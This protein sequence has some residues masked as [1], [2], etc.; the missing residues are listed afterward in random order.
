MTI[1]PKKKTSKDKNEAENVERPLSPGGPAEVRGGARRPSSPGGPPRWSSPPPVDHDRGPA[2]H[3]PPGRYEETA[4][5]SGNKRRLRHRSPPH[6]VARKQ[7]HDNTRTAALCAGASAGIAHARL[8][9]IRQATTSTAAPDPRTNATSHGGVPVGQALAPE[10]ER[11]ACSGYNSEDECTPRPCDQNVE[12]MERWFETQLKEKR[13]Y[14]IKQMGEDGACL[15]RAVADQVYGDQEM[16]G[17]VRQHCVDYMAKN[18]DFYKQFV[19]EDFTTYLNRKRADNCHGNHIEMQALSELYNRPIEVYKCTSLDPINT[20]HSSYE[21]DNEPIRLSY[22]RNVHYNSVV[23]PHKAT[24]G[25]GLGLPGLQPGLADKNLIREAVRMSEDCHIEQTM[26]QDK[27]RET[28]WE[29]TQETIEEQV[30]RESYLQWLQEQEK[31]AKS[32]TSHRSASATCSTSTDTLQTCLDG[33]ASPD[34]PRT[35]R[36]PRSHGGGNGGGGSGQNS[37]KQMESDYMSGVSCPSPLSPII[38]STSSGRSA[39]SGCGIN[40]SSLS[41]EG[42]VGGVDY[43]FPE[44]ASI[45]NDLPPQMF[46]LSDYDDDDVIARVLAESQREYLDSLKTMTVAGSSSSPGGATSSSSSSSLPND[47]PDK[48]KSLMPKDV[49]Q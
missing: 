39:A 11:G 29:V 43:G 49:R 44:T 2:G 47:R 8:S 20:F 42:A 27:L 25:V 38:P 5:G 35:S 33:S 19:T 26:L 14:I 18:V 10:E 1:L 28:D 32:R 24:I 46:G 7:R 48:G 9:G 17:I 41:L 40:S 30:A 13:G 3:E 31:Y 23:N 36:S 12:E 6:G 45:M 15:F 16:H 37:P 34:Q 21:T 4:S 22:H